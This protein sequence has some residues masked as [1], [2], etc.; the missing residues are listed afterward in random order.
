MDGQRVLRVAA[1]A[2]IEAEGSILIMH[3]SEIDINRNW[4]IP[5]GIR[6]NINETINQTAVR[7]VL[8]ETGIDIAGLFGRV[9]KVGEWP[10]IDHG[11]HVKII[12]VFFHFKLPKRLAITLSHEH[13]DLAWVNR[14]NYKEYKANPEVYEIVEELLSKP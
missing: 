14:L 10:A 3:P 1:K 4:Q 12:A 7:E 8:E 9:F 5:G 2:V 6:D 13:D 11:K